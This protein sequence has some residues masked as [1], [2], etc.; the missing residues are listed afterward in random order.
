MRVDANTSTSSA[1]LFLTSETSADIAAMD[2]LSLASG[3]LTPVFNSSDVFSFSLF[4]GGFYYLTP[5]TNPQEMNL[6]LFTFSTNR[7]KR[8]ATHITEARSLAQSISG[9]LVYWMGF[10]I[11]RTDIVSGASSLYCS[12]SS[13]CDAQSNANCDAAYLVVTNDSHASPNNL[14]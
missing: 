6:M 13:L 14:I 12:L 11:M 1:Q 7:T 2:S 4:W 3:Q 9:A 10:D 5:T 8:V